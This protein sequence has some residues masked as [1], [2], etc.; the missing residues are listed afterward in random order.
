MPTTNSHRT[1]ATHVLKFVVV[2]GGIAG[3]ATAYTLR[4][5]GHEIAVVEKRNLMDEVDFGPFISRA[6]SNELRYAQTKG[7]L[8]CPPNMTT[9]LSRWPG[10]EEFL[11]RTASK[12]S[13]LSF[14]VG[15]ESETVGFMKFYTEIMVQLGA[16]FF[17]VQHDDLRREILSLCLATGVEFIKGKVVDIEVAPTQAEYVCVSLEDGQSVE[18]NIIIGADGYKSMLRPLVCPEVTQQVPPVV[19]GV[20]VSIP[21]ERLLEREDLAPL[22]EQRQFTLWMGDGSSV[23]AALDRTTNTFNIAL[24]TPLP[25]DR[26]ADVDPVLPPEDEGDCEPEDWPADGDEEDGWKS[27]PVDLDQLPFDLSSYDPRL[28]EAIKLGESMQYTK[29]YVFKQGDAVS[30]DG[31]IVLVGD[32]AHAVLMHGSHN[33]SM[34]IEDAAMLGALFS[35]LKNRKEVAIL[36]ET[37][38]ELRLKRVQATR[39]SEYQ[40]LQM[41]CLPSGAARDSRDAMLSLTKTREFKDFDDCNAEDVLVDAWERYLL[42]F[43]YDALEVVEDWLS[44]YG[45]AMKGESEANGDMDSDDTP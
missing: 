38:E 3:L 19:T 35:H 7:T 39:D 28:L 17:V 1:R 4:T 45:W 41:I 27:V 13:G 9:L 14:R 20:N 16:E 6:D 10:M 8:R 30:L 31:S 24:C 43:N 5:A 44:M 34:A 21:M 26:A 33:T 36:L 2:G 12:I 22:C 23:N 40:S 11:F 25:A 42:V 32:A 29:Q 15:E 18:G 37:Y